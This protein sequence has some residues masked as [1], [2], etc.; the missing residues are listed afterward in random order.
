MKDK[1]R[2]EIKCERLKYNGI[3]HVECYPEHFYKL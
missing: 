2:K 1:L 3:F